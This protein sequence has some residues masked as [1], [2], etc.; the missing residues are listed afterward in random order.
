MT[1]KRGLFSSRRRALGGVFW[2]LD[3]MTLAWHLVFLFHFYFPTARR[4]FGSMSCLNSEYPERPIRHC[5]S[6][7]TFCSI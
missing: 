4:Q 1:S 3:N 5:S 2:V 7:S 6:Y